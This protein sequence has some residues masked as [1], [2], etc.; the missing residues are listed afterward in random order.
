MIDMMQA[1]F[2]VCLSEDSKFP[3]PFQNHAAN[4]MMEIGPLACAKGP[5]GD[6]DCDTLNIYS[7]ISHTR[8]GV[9]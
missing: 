1:E 4:G 9:I 5:E 8:W 2:T 7:Y 3:F 6:G